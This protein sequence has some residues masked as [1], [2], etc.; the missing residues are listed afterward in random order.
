MSSSRWRAPLSRLTT[1]ESRRD[2]SCQRFFQGR[3]VIF[4][5]ATVVARRPALMKTQRQALTELYIFGPE[6]LTLQREAIGG[7]CY[8][9]VRFIL[10][11]ALPVT[12]PVCGGVR[13]AIGISRMAVPDV[14]MYA[15]AF[16]RPHHG[17]VILQGFPFHIG[18]ILK[19]GG[20]VRSL[21]D[22]LCRGQERN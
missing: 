14:R 21:I 22:R 15:S 16:S 20:G 7:S 6:N 4:L 13:S 12:E 8:C 2:C 11:T 18:I 5:V 9:N 1:S 19:I 10:G 17:L 3:H